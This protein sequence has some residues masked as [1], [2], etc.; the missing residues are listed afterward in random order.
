MYG[1]TLSIPDAS[2]EDWYSLLLGEAAP[3][4]LGPRD[5]KRA[6]ARALVERFHDAVRG[7]A[8][9]AAFDRV[10][11]RHELPDEI[12]PVAIPAGG[13]HRPP[14]GAAG[15]G[16]RRLHLGG[17]AGPRPGGGAARRRAGRSEARPPGSRAERPRAPVRQAPLRPRGRGGRRGGGG[18]VSGPV[19]G[20]VSPAPGVSTHGGQL[21]LRPRATATWSTSPKGWHSVVRTAGVE[22]GIVTVFVVGSTAA[23]TTMEY[24]PGG[25]ADLQALLERLIPARGR[26]R[27]Q[28]AEPRLQFP[29]P[30][31]RLADRPLGVVSAGGRASGPGNLAADRADRLRRSAT[32]T[33][34]C[35]P[36]RIL[37]DRR[38][39]RWPASARSSRVDAEIRALYSSVRPGSDR[40]P[41][42]PFEEDYLPEGVRRS[43]KTQQHAHPSTDSSVEECV[44]VRRRRS[45][46]VPRGSLE[47]R[48]QD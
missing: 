29:R 11:I 45:I 44:Q 17:A 10:H 5:A 47:R 48:C 33:H 16:L 42:A 32:R 2:L 9:E 41:G 27:A 24:E 40:A 39:E 35:R 6:L 46:D 1:K 25:V 31:A 21:R 12:H 36:G 19:D 3:A 13:W 22:R 28:P 34:G 15:R 7:H 30:P 18:P 8:A 14:A 23:V 43:L 20:P 4:G 38:A 26:L 37:S